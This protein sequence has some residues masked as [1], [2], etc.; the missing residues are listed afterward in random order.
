MGKTAKSYPYAF[1]VALD[2][3][4]INGL[5]GLAGVCLFLFDPKHNHYG[6][7]I[8]FFDGIAGGHTV[9][10]NRSGT[11]GFLGNTGQHLLFYDAR[12]L[13]EVA[14][15]STLRFETPTTSLQG[16]TH[17]VWLSDDEIVTPIGEYFYR[18]KISDL[19]RPTRLNPHL[20]KLPHGM[21]RTASGRYIVYGSM[22]S[23]AGSDGEAR[24]V[25]IWDLETNEITVL[26]LPATCWHVVAHPKADIFYAV[27][28]RVA[29][30]NYR[31]WHNWGMAYL[32]EYAFEI[33][34]AEK[35]VLRHWSAGR[36]VP[37][38][39]NS[40][41]ALSDQELIFCN[42]GSQSI[43]GLD[44][45]SFAKFRLID[46]RPSLAAQMGRPREVLN[47]IFESFARGNVFS[48]SQHFLGALKVSRFSLLDSVY[49][50]QLSA[51]QSLLF[52][53]NRGLN[54]ITVYDYPSGEI[55]L[56]AT[57]PELQKYHSWLF[58]TSDPGL[59]FHHGFLLG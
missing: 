41:L 6:Y 48:N 17:V 10:V 30:Q 19:E 39:I 46:E 1:H 37:A 8:E 51:D 32:K 29:P 47:Q 50:C 12:T 24:Q 23:P 49:A 52:T 40:D 33:D 53:A 13:V 38:H 7:K 22:D 34:A 58:P 20:V 16:S 44:L 36:E 4:G 43:V 28:F 5:E 57:M 2:G 35:K 54:H 11:I 21:K 56:R 55:R 27:S 15:I 31:D 14:R 25:G 3:N 42:G 45:R 26:T 59:G 18:F 9:S